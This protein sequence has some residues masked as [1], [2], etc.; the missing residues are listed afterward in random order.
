MRPGPRATDDRHDLAAENRPGDALRDSGTSIIEIL[1]AIVLLGTVVVATL[2]SLTTSINA[3]ALDRD[4]ANAHAWLQTG[5]DML[6]ARHTENCTTDADL[7]TIRDDYEALVQSTKNP[8]NWS[9]GNITVTGVEMFV[10]DID[11]STG[12]G[13]E[14]WV[15]TCHP[16][17]TGLQRVGLRVRG[18]DGRIVEEVTVI[19]DD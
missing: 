19:I 12:I 5:A 8:E 15:T 3:S 13:T 4:H 18:E 1:I 2:T 16:K 17:R 9:P 11:P 7:A 10:L 14:S 6:Y